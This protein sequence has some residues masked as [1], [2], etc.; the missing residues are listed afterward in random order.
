MNSG[1]EYCRIMQYCPWFKITVFN[2]EHFVKQLV[3][4]KFECRCKQYLVLFSL[5]S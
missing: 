1:S 4:A 5:L 2:F 3:I